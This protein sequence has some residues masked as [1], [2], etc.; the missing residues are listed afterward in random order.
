MHFETEAKLALYKF[1][2]NIST[3][4]NNDFSNF[5]WIGQSP[6]GLKEKFKNLKIFR[7]SCRPNFV[8]RLA[9]RSP[10]YCKPLIK[11]HEREKWRTG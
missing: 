5:I 1:F 8:I 11:A 3:Q 6:Y 2:G 4:S 7:I 9:G 10:A